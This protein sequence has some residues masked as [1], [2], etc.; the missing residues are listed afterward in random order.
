MKK[1]LLWLTNFIY[2]KYEL[3]DNH[4]DTIKQYLEKSYNDIIKFQEEYKDRNILVHCFMGSSRSASILVANN[5]LKNNISIEESIKYIK[6]KRDLVNINTT[7]IKDLK[8]W[9]NEGDHL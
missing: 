7:F 8:E 9:Y 3:Y 1:H 6:G 5:S 4:K 2:K